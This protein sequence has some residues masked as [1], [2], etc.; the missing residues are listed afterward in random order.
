VK[1]I[2]LELID[3]LSVEEMFKVIITLKDVLKYFPER[4]SLPKKEGEE[5][6]LLPANRDWM[7]TVWH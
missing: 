5:S 2:E 3:E 4:W 6:E 1:K 7:A